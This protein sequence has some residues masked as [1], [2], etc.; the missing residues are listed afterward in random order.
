MVKN[1]VETWI[2]MNPGYTAAMALFL[3]IVAVGVISYIFRGDPN[4]SDPFSVYEG[5]ELPK[6]YELDGPGRVV[7]EMGDNFD[8]RV[9]C[10]APYAPIDG[11]SPRAISCDTP[12]TDFTLAGCEIDCTGVWSDCDA[13]CGRTSVSTANAEQ[14]SGCPEPACAPGT[15]LC[16]AGSPSGIDCAGV[17]SDCDASCGRTSVSTANAE[18]ISGCPEPAC[19]P[20]TDLCP[21][22]VAGGAGGTQPAGWNLHCNTPLSTIGYTYDWSSVQGTPSV[23]IGTNQFPH[24]ESDPTSLISC[25]G[26]E[27][28]GTAPSATVCPSANTPY[29]LSGCD[30]VE[31][32]PLLIVAPDRDLRPGD[33]FFVDFFANT[34]A[35]NTVQC[36]T[37]QTPTGVCDLVTFHTGVNFN[38]DNIEW[39]DDNEDVLSNEYQANTGGSSSA[40]YYNPPRARV[41]STTVYA[42]VGRL[43]LRAEAGSPMKNRMGLF[44]LFNLKF[45]VK[46]NATPGIYTSIFGPGHIYTFGNGLGADMVTPGI[47]GDSMNLDAEVLK[48]EIAH[49]LANASLGAPVGDWIDDPTYPASVAEGWR[50]RVAPTV[51]IV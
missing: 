47:P 12:N 25:S 51:T 15:D 2:N 10:K 31:R 9:K 37:R 43:V 48:R 49:R 3:L 23:L 21:A 27:Y 39:I 24:A 11:E 36:S 17:W 18:Q 40:P 8:V 29:T 45:R 33:E 30:A 7:M 20:G 4:C 50:S 35:R 44:F 41:G 32:S 13:S 19:A 42:D 38:E 34:N 5:E 28:T 46:A 16:P 22:G 14:I 1:A 26:S 6:G